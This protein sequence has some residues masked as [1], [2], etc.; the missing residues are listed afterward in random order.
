MTGSLVCNSSARWRYGEIDFSSG[1]IGG[2]PRIPED[3]VAAQMENTDKLKRV[4]IWSN[5]RSKDRDRTKIQE[6]EDVRSRVVRG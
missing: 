3:M 4:V 2:R 6:N 5:K 1:D